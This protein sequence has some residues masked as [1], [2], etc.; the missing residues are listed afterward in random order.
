MTKFAVTRSDVRGLPCAIELE[1][2]ILASLLLYPISTAEVISDKKL[3]PEHLYLK[4]HQFLLGTCVEILQAGKLLDITSI[5]IHLQQLGKLEDIGGQNKLIELIENGQAANS[6]PHLEAW[7]DKIIEDDVRRKGIQR[8]LQSIDDLHNPQIQ[9]SE[10][11]ERASRDT[12]SLCVKET[13]RYQLTSSGE[14]VASVFNELQS[15]DQVKYL[16]GLKD[17]DNLTDGLSLGYWV[18]AGRASMGKTHFGLFLAHAMSEYEPVLIISAEMPTQKIAQRLL[19]K[20]SRIESHRLKSKRIANDEW[21]ILAEAGKT[22]A[23]LPIEI[24]DKPNP[25]EIDIRQRVQQMIR[26]Y[27]KPPGMILVDYIQKL[28]WY[29]NLNRTQDLERISNKLYEMSKDYKTRVVAL[30]QLNRG[31]ENRADKRPVMSD[32]KDCG[33]IE[34]D[35]DVLILL[36]RDEYY[37]SESGD[38]GITELNLVKNRDAETGVV[39]VLHELR[40]GNYI[41]LDKPVIHSYSMKKPAAVP[42]KWESEDDF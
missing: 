7:I 3:K 26:K 39:K 34:Q 24:Y 12:Y 29:P 19:A 10:A 20:I 14:A 23:S 15:S 1:E 6:A 27:G 41:G 31:V 9:P 35:A 13:E 28:S 18:V 38:K 42:T 37:N 8:Y 33:S 21:P 4:A 40:Y 22:L 32:V 16:S 17:L 36:Y 25:Q 11:F 5:A 30:A 2:N